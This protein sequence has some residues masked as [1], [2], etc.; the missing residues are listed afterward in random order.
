MRIL[1]H[2]GKYGDEYWLAD[3]PERL[4]AAMRKLF[5]RLDEWGCYEDDEEGIAEARDGDIRA[6]KW[7][8]QRR[9]DYEYEGWDL[10]EAIDPCT[11]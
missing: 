1:I 6:I 5:A 3:T 8:L 9:Q 11:P 10:E 7:I 4:E 2:H